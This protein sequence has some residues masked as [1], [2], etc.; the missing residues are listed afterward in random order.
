MFDMNYVIY[1]SQH[2]KVVRIIIHILQLGKL[3][4][5]QVRL[6]GP[7]S[8][9][10]LMSEPGFTPKKSDFRTFFANL[11]SILCRVEPLPLCGVWSGDYCDL[12]LERQEFPSLGKLY[13][14]TCFLAEP[15]RDNSAA[16]KNDSGFLQG[17]LI[18]LIPS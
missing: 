13:Y 5:I 18:F 14:T 6:Y 16:T 1:S 8:Q 12:P 15:P 4:I 7:G 17:K 10:Q 3:R 11:Y 2:S 9:S